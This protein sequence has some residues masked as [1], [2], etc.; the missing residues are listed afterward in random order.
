MQQSI[1]LENHI[2]E[3]GVFEYGSH[4]TTTAVCV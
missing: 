1:L 4:V 2:W 3:G